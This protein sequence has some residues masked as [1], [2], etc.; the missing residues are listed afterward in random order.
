MS[1]S[2]FKFIRFFLE[3]RED[4]STARYLS[5]KTGYSADT[6]RGY[7]RL[8]VSE[9]AVRIKEVPDDARVRLYM[10]KHNVSLYEFARI[11]YNEKDD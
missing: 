3:I 4:Y 9:N 7:I 11:I 6:V 10:L 8:L 5:R 1:N 2:I